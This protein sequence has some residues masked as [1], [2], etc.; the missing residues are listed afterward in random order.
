MEDSGLSASAMTPTIND[1]DRRTSDDTN[2]TTSKSADFGTVKS[3][4][5]NSTNLSVK[6]LI[7]S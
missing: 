6:L 7:F 3:A 5:E 1:S 2:L 4:D